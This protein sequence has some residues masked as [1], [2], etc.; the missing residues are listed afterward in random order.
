M[1]VKKKFIIVFII[2]LILAIAYFGY[3]GFLL[4]NYNVDISNILKKQLKDSNETITIIKNNYSSDDKVIG[5]KDLAYKKI[6]DNF[7]YNENNSSSDFERPYFSYYLDYKDIG[8]FTALFRIGIA[9][10]AYEMLTLP[11]SDISTFG[12]SFKGTNRKELLQKYNLKND[13][14]IYKYIIDHYDDNMNIF[15]SRDKIELNYLIKTYA[16]VAIP[17][18]NINLIKGDVKGYMY[19]VSEGALY[20]VHLINKETNYVFGFF[21]GKGSKYFTFDKVKEFIS[22][23]HFKN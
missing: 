22:N 23:V 5:F 20:E 9:Y 6:E 10:N 19:T 17:N 3:K 13:Y 16:N 14:D 2:V 7:I 4:I 15:S 21:N 8:N 12:F 1:F 18:S 11:S